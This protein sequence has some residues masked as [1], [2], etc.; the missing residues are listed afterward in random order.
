MALNILLK[1]ALNI[2]DKNMD[3]FMKYIDEGYFYKIILPKDDMD[4]WKILLKNKDGKIILK[5]DMELLGIYKCEQVKN[6]K[7]RDFV[8]A[9]MYAQNKPLMRAMKKMLLYGIDIS[10]KPYFSQKVHFCTGIFRLRHLIFVDLHIAVASYFTKIS[11]VFPIILPNKENI[12]EKKDKFIKLEKTI[13]N[14]VSNLIIHYLF[15][16]N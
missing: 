16:H 11:F 9:W 3:K 2:Y 7:Y 1:D 8:W 13:K 10:T 12:F 4:T 6:V 5:K 15:I 14:N